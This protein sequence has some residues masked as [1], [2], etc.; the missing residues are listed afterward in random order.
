[1]PTTTG[2]LWP[3]DVTSSIIDHSTTSSLDL[4]NTHDQGSK[5]LSVPLTSTVD[6]VASTSPRT[7]DITPYAV[8][9]TVGALV[10]VIV[11]LIVIV[12][13]LL[14]VKRNRQKSP[15]NVNF[16]KNVGLLSYDNALY[17]SSKETDSCNA[18]T[19]TCTVVDIAIQVYCMVSVYIVG[20]SYTVKIL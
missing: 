6:S 5:T 16:N 10:V 18:H 13:I 11:V 20:C 9:G 15:D 19:S 2:A 7:L 12:M 3:P 8:G 4:G 17:D 1:M 14:L